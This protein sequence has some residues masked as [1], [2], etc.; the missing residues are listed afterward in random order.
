MLALN[1]LVRCALV[2][3]FNIFLGIACRILNGADDLL[4]FT[5]N[6]L[7]GAFHL[8]IRVAGP[9]TYLALR[10]TCR[11][12]NCTFYPILIH[13]ST[14]VASYS[15]YLAFLYVAASRDAPSLADAMSGAVELLL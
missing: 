1:L 12:I 14:S 7:H 6:L 9:L 4:R 5:F 11:I 15:V 2:L 13:N 3:A 10:T 8:S